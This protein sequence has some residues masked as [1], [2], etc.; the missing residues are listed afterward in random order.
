MRLVK[1]VMAALLV[2]LTSSTAFG[3]I[4]DVWDLSG[5]MQNV[6]NPGPAID[7]GA[8]GGGTATWSYLDGG[9]SAFTT[10]IISNPKTEANPE[11]PTSGIGWRNTTNTHVTLST[12]ASADGSNTNF[13][14]GSTG[15]HAGYAA[16]WTTDHAGK[17]QIEISGYNART[18]SGTQH[19]NLVVTSSGGGITGSPLFVSQVSHKGIANAAFLPIQEVTLAAGGFV[20]A[21]MQGNPGEDWAGMTITITEVIPEPTSFVLFS[22]AAA[23]L[24]IGCRRRSAAC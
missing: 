13:Q 21:H 19:Q 16:L 6:S 15:G 5:D 2:T 1:S 17:Y 9:L 7:P 8:A 3:L 24:V 23:G 20:Q 18:A 12:Y 11:L 14:V 4:G 10:A 22:I